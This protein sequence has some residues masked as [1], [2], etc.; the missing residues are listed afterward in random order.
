MCG[1]SF[2]LRQFD[3]IKNLHGPLVRVLSTLERK[4]AKS[5]PRVEAP[6]TNHLRS[7]V[8]NLEKYKAV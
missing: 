5:P 6:I 4:G 7:F 2:M 1:I 8:S 3:V